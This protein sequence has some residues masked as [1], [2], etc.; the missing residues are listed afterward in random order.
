L[1]LEDAKKAAAFKKAMED[2]KKAAAF[3][4]AMEGRL[5]LEIW[6]GAEARADALQ[7]CRVA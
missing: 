5:E 1:E 3:K 6:R 7:A 4:K 2:A